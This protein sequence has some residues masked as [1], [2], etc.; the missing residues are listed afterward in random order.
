MTGTAVAVGKRGMLNRIQQRG[1]RSA[2]A[3]VTGGT[4]LR[5]RFDASMTAAH[6]RR[7]YLVAIETDLSAR[8]YQQGGVDAG[9][10][11]MT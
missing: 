11:G 6:F 4:G 9:V 5:R 8:L 7:G 2:V 10:T 1:L 3:V